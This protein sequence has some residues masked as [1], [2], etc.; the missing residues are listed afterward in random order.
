MRNAIFVNSHRELSTRLSVS[1]I[2]D[3]ER[4]VRGS[5]HSMNR[6]VV[7]LAGPP[8]AVIYHTSLILLIA[9]NCIPPLKY[10]EIRIH[11]NR[12]VDT[13]LPHH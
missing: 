8:A 6:F 4:N 13:V 11:Q 7:P 12:E 1:D 2:T 3:I 5:G 10:Q 9:M